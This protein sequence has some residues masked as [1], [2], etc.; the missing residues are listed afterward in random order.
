MQNDFW[1]KVGFDVIRFIIIVFFIISFLPNSFA[2]IL[3]FEQ[4]LEQIRE[5]Q[6]CTRKV[7]Q[8]NSAQIPFTLKVF[9]DTTKNAV[10]EIKQQGTT[11]PITQRTNQV[12]TFYTNGTDQYEIHMEMNY[13]DAKPR[14][15]YYEYLSQ[16]VLTYS[17][18]EKF[19]GT[20]FCMSMFVNTVIPPKA[21][22]KEEIFGESLN[23]IAQIPAMVIAFNANSV[24]TATSISF[25]WLLILGIG[26]VAVLTFI[27][28][29]VGKRNFNAMIRDG[30]DAVNVVTESATKIDDMVRSL[31]KLILSLRDGTGV[32]LEGGITKKV[33]VG[34]MLQP[35]KKKTFFSRW[36]KDEDEVLTLVP[37]QKSMGEEILD[38]LKIGT[39]ETE[40]EKV[41]TTEYITSS[42]DYILKPQPPR[43]IELIR[44]IDFPEVRLKAG[45]YEKF[46]YPELNA[47]Y[48]W[49]T[50]YRKHM[51]LLLRE[52]PK[53]ELTKQE[54]ACNV[55]HTAL[56]LKLNQRVESD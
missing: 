21:P 19:E 4:Q 45:V 30:R 41:P 26:V 10:L 53:K 43:F 52:I 37:N 46:S 22:T 51:N 55:I 29:N 32:P 18:Q 15:V 1:F 17:A 56:Y 9:Y 11:F 13:D 12:M 6:E 47:I 50:H 5:P 28:S 40:V 20:K 54:I 7:I 48:S 3:P 34:E 33:D 14:Q 23:Y 42:P 36:K 38:E 8:A 16:D 24:T 39:Q 44:G 49:I 27:N 35:K 2:Q 25:M 31:T